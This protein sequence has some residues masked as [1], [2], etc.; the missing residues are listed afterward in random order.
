MLI[1]RVCTVAWV[2][3]GMCAIGLYMGSDI[4]PDQIYG[5]MARTCYRR[6]CQD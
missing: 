2:I 1:K 4:E 5:L 3:V 6:S